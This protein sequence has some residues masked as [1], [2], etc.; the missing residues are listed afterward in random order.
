MF[1]LYHFRVKIHAVTRLYL[2]RLSQHA[3]STYLFFLCLKE[4]VKPMFG[5]KSKEKSIQNRESGNAQF[6]AGNFKQA[7]MLYSVAVFAAPPPS[8]AYK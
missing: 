1:C 3:L 7:Q 6:Y 8:K 4:I 5:T 2:L